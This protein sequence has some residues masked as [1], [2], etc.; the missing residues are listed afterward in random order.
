MKPINREWHKD[1]D[2]A[3]AMMN[4]EIPKR[5][6]PRPEPKPK[7]P[8]Q[9]LTLH[10]KLGVTEFPATMIV[11]VR[12]G[13]WMLPSGREFDRELFGPYYHLPDLQAP[14]FGK[15]AGHTRAPKPL[16]SNWPKEHQVHGEMRMKWHVE[17]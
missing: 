6:A 2:L 5:P 7:L 13:K 11:I 16:A 8:D 4:A 15:I 10:R 3:L 9:V 1:L 12:G 17:H 14:R